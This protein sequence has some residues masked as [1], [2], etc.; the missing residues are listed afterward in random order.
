[1][2]PY[3]ERGGV[4][5]YLGDCLEH[6]SAVTPG[7]YSHFVTDPPYTAA[8]GSTNGRY[9]DYDDQ[10]F[11][12]WLKDVGAG[13]RRSVRADGCGFMF[14]D[15]R[16]VGIVGRSIREPG[17][18]QTAMAWG[19]A[20]ALVWDRDGIGLG[21]PFRNSYEMIAFAKSGGW[22]DSHLPKNPPTV[23]R[24]RYPYG[25]REFHGAEKPLGLVSQLI[26]WTG[27]HR[28]SSPVFDPF[29]GSGT[30]LLAAAGLG[31]RSVGVE[32]DEATAEIAAKRIDAALSQTNLFAA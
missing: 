12:Y 20:Q 17:N 16:T 15:W 18:R 32:I 26:E 24:H 10:F 7:T 21:S 4:T 28:S 19:I 3:Y 8:G 14:C 13:L 2:K 6:M 31:I 29:A 30:T 9:S 25:A 27:A 22:S 11:A 5:L 1:M 23:V